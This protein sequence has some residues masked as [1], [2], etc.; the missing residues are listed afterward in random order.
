[1]SRPFIY[2]KIFF[3]NLKMLCTECN[4]KLRKFKDGFICQNNHKFL[5]GSKIHNNMSEEN[6]IFADIKSGK[7]KTNL[8]PECQTPA[9]SVC[10][11]KRSEKRCINNHVWT[12]KYY[13][14]DKRYLCINPPDNGKHCFDFS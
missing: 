2:L 7:I 10:M 5:P 12:R 13:Q 9:V 1:M 6:K 11:C 4:T 3:K 14:G 8:C